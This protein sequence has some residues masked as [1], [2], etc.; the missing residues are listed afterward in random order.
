MYNPLWMARA[1]WTKY[2]LKVGDEIEATF[3][4]AKNGSG[5]GRHRLGH[6]VFLG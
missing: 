5:N 3:H 4:P 2:T 1:G 6:A